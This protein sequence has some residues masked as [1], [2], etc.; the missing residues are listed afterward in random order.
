MIISGQV[1]TQRIPLLRRIVRCQPQVRKPDFRC[2]LLCEAAAQMALDQVVVIDAEFA[3]AELQA[4]G[5]PRYSDLRGRCFAPCSNGFLGQNPQTHYEP[6][7]TKE[8]PGVGRERDRRYVLLPRQ[9]LKADAAPL[10]GS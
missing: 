9:A 3:I 4:A 6:C 7:A 8:Y 5:I 10:L 1:G 2:Q